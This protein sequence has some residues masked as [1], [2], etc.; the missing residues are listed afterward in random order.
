MAADTLFVCSMATWLRVC[1]SVIIVKAQPEMQGLGSA[2][3]DHPAV[4]V[5][6]ARMRDGSRP[7]QRGD[8]FKVG[9]VVE[10]GGMRGVVTGAA[11]QAMHD[12]GLR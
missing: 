11:L 1:R 2:Q 5:V 6:R 7:G 4:E 12:L 10:G 9:L 8:G 3:A